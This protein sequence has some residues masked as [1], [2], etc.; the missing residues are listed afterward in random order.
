MADLAARAARAGVGRGEGLARARAVEADGPPEPLLN[1]WSARLARVRRPAAARAGASGASSLRASG[2]LAPGVRIGANFR[3]R[4][5]RIGPV[6]ARRGRTGAGP[7][8]A[9]AA[10]GLARVRLLRLAGLR[11]P[12]LPLGGSLA[13]PGRGS[14]PLIYGGAVSALFGT[15]AL[16][17][18]VTWRPRARQWMR[19][20]DHSMIFV[21]IA[22]TYTPVALVALAGA[23]CHE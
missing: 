1:P 20:L 4:E 13:R 2:Y 10:G 7:H 17:H 19:R 16:Y 3:C 11:Q 6:L 9:T 21:L 18:R 23:S 5:H 15:S 8:Q 14:P 12:G 22:G